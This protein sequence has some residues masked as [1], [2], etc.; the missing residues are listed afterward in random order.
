MTSS[1]NQS[2]V[3]Q[4]IRYHM[5][6]AGE[7]F[8]VWGINGW[9]VLPE[10]NRPAGTG[11]ENGVMHTPMAPQ[12]DTFVTKIQL[13]AGASLDY[14]FQIR[15][16]R[17]GTAISWIWDGDHRTT[18]SEDGIIKATSNPKLAVTQ[19]IR[20]RMPEAGEVFLLWGV[21]GWAAVPEE[22]RPVGTIVRDDIMQTPMVRKGDTFVVQVQVP[23]GTTI[24][25]GFLITKNWSGSA[26]EAV[27]DREG[28]YNTAATRDDVVEIQASLRLQQERTPASIHDTESPTG[29]R[30]L[31]STRPKVS[32]NW[33]QL[34]YLRDLLRELVV[35]DMKLRYK[36]SLLGI[37]WSLL[38]PL[39]QMLV[40]VFLSRRVLSL[41]IP[42][43][44]SFVYTG[45]LAWSWFQSALLLTTGAITGNRELVRRPGFP[46]AIL[47]VVTVTTNLIH[48]LLALPVP[49]IFFVLG[50]GRL[51]GAILALPLVILLQFLLILGLG[52]LV[53]TVQV[54]FRDTQHL[55]GVF[56]SLLFYLTPVFYDASIVPGRYQTLYRLNPMFHLI[57]AYRAIL[58]QGNLPDLVALLALG[59]LTVALLW[60]GHTVFT[61]AS[62]RFVEE[63]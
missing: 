60:L 31:A 7:V 34:T 48:F 16:T 46:T 58:I 50:G 1:Q 54:T 40:F 49:M 45:V 10:E 36:R 61:R 30:D 3:T 43:Y 51:T 15:R 26:I 5:P 37:A 8:L 6:E 32:L 18:P 38:N 28:G 42:N 44:P 22:I 56:F 23:A 29:H 39:F 62:Y 14:G 25:Y 63:L 4:Q 20:Y 13:P 41:D 35:R 27:F 9:N 12:G 52:Y 2:I 57:T 59:V 47:P 19:E 53:A 11:V 24:N 55:L 17:D 21:N 33:R